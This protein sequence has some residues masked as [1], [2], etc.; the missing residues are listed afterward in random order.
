MYAVVCARMRFGGH[1]RRPRKRSD[2]P[3]QPPKIIISY[4]EAGFVILSRSAEVGFQC[5][6]ED[7]CSLPARFLLRLAV[8][9]PDGKDQIRREYRKPTSSMS[10]QTRWGPSYVD[11][12]ACRNLLTD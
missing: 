12:V 6:V 3:P 11:N 4:C 8:R 5:I 1:R 9:C 10:S 7:E 2:P